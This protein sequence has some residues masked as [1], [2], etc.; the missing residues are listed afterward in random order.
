MSNREQTPRTSSGV[1]NS[2]VR[3]SDT[4]R[5]SVAAIGFGRWRD[6]FLLQASEDEPV[7]RIG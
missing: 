7:D 6:A 2:P 4:R 1:G 5:I 3:S